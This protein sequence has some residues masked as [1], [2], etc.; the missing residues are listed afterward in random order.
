MR[1]LTLGD[2]RVSYHD[3]AEH[4]RMDIGGNLVDGI[5]CSPVEVSENMNSWLMRL[6]RRVA[7]R[8]EAGTQSSA[9]AIQVSH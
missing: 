5:F 3:T 7:G 4:Q 6:L 2:V 9:V 8:I 1:H